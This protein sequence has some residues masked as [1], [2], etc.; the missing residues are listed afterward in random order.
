MSSDKPGSKLDANDGKLQRDWQA[1]DQAKAQENE[2]GNAGKG[3]GKPKSD[4]HTKE[5][6]PRGDMAEAATEVDKQIKKS[7]DRWA[8]AR[9]PRQ[10]SV[11]KKL[12]HDR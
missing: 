12:E 10:K 4:D 9:P 1:K 11:D 3:D 6:K 7:H 2:Q 8:R 5:L